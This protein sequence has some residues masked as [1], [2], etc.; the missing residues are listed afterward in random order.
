MEF[1]DLLNGCAPDALVRNAF[2]IL[3]M[4]ATA[5]YLH[6]KSQELYEALMEHWE[7][8]VTK[9]SVVFVPLYTLC[10]KV[11]NC[12]EGLQVMYIVVT[13]YHLICNILGFKNICNILSPHYK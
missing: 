3:R 6:L 10:G 8:A 12:T 7:T 13:F 1:T 9:K 5:R 2:V 11:Q 4:V